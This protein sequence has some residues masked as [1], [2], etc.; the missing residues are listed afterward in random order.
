[1]VVFNHYLV[2]I[3]LSFNSLDDLN[4]TSNLD[5]KL[6]LYKMKRE[7]KFFGR[8]REILEV[9]QALMQARNEFVTV[10]GEVRIGKTQGN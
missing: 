7:P 9:V 4:E 3:A 8:K 6:H 1:M 2:D 5:S 10:K